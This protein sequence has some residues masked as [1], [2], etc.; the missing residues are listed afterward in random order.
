MSTVSYTVSNTGDR[1][2]VIPFEYLEQSH[3][4]AYVN[5]F[6]TTRWTI[7]EPNTLRFD[8]AIPTV[9][10]DI[11]RIE[12]KTQIEYPEVVFQSGIPIR[13][14][15]VK[16]SNDQLLF[17]MQELNLETFVGLSKN[18][19]LT[20]WDAE[21]LRIE[22]LA[23]PTQDGDATNKSY[24]V[25]EIATAI[26]NIGDPGG[27]GLPAPTVNDTG[28][29][30]RLLQ[31]G[32]GTPGVDLPVYQIGGMAQAELICVADLSSEPVSG[33]GIAIGY[34]SDPAFGSNTADAGTL[35]PLAFESLVLRPINGLMA[36]NNGTTGDYINLPPGK[37]NVT[38]T[39]V[40]TTGGFNLGL[41]VQPH[42]ASI[43]LRQSDG[44][45]WK[46]TRQVFV[47][48]G[49]GDTTA[50]RGSVTLRIDCQIDTATSTTLQLR[51]AD[52][53]TA[54]AQQSEIY[55]LDA[56]VHVREVIE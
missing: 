26:A 41:S 43:G 14:R 37:F 45:L 25:N 19:S 27:S 38:A 48:Y 55:L 16:R 20:A 15:E 51:V 10:G 31:E 18:P 6:A 24:V 47:G 22:N 21:S 23:A 29:T 35:V 39:A 32:T 11:I 40:V 30:I 13:Q 1:D 34:D 17:K 4:R 2:F 46:E 12:R 54:S 3:L 49:P 52:N 50:A 53:T 28:R 56:N 5:D 36:P 44:T 7:V 8:E 9:A 42:Y 33:S